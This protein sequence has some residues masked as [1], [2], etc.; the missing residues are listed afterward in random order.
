MAPSTAETRESTNTDRIDVK[1]IKKEQ[2]SV[3]DKFYSGLFDQS[4]RDEIRKSVEASKPY[5]HCKISKLVNED[6]LRRV[7]KEIFSQL[8][9]T[10]K[11]TDIY[12]VN[13]TGDLANMDGLSEEERSK[14]SA[15]FE[16]RNAI[17]S[18]EFRDF[19]SEVT[20][21][22]P[23][24]PSKMDMSVNTYTAGCHLLNHDDVIGTRRVSFILYMP[25]EPDEDWDPAFGGALEL[26]PVVERDK[27]ANEPS[28][29]VPPKWNQFAMFTVLPGYSFHS[30][31]EVVVED[32]P[33]LSIQGW[34]HFPQEGEV[35]YKPDAEK[36]D[37]LSSLQQIE[38]AVE[39]KESFEEYKSGALDESATLGLTE[40]DLKELVTW[41][42][43]VYLNMEFLTQVT[44]KFVEESAIQLKGFLNDELYDKI[45]AATLK[46]DQM[47]KFTEPIMPPHGTGIR[48][49]WFVQGSPVSQRFL[50]LS[51]DDLKDDEETSV[52][53]ADL[54]SRFQSEAFRHW[55]AV[56][57]QLL[58]CGYRGLARR[59][60]PGHDYTLATTNMRGQAVLDATLCLATAPTEKAA[61]QWE[62]CEYGGYECYMAPHEGDDDPATYRTFDDDGALLTIGAGSN[63]LSLVLKDEGVMRFIKYIS[64][65]APGAR[66]DISFEYDLP[67]EKEEESA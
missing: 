66:W 26:Y 41:I 67:E 12:K 6:L 49:S 65:R 57:S 3:K 15:L 17:Y 25:G 16:L 4:S 28:V 32:K 61:E 50:K 21:C 2:Q 20:G 18:Q 55:L 46:A 62:S 1:R 58:P 42:N 43:P 37:T 5:P 8:N 59:F 40:E 63:E 27:P 51:D 53:F 14:L 39:A 36:S 54:R 47:D 31:E 56:V 44:E 64:A 45:K 24:S 52:L 38:A 34:F 7:H 35:G 11:E 60:R 19:V 10:T 33:R 22:G 9:F 23:L 13:Q 48:G 30:V 29:S